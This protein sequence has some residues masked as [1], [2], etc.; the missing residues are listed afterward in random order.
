MNQGFPAREVDSRSSR[1]R[2]TTSE[3]V[4]LYPNPR[5]E[6]C[7]DCLIEMFLGRVRHSMPKIAEVT[8][9]G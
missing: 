6:V 4:R 1:V 7:L 5:K 8:Q 2:R 3:S 9:V